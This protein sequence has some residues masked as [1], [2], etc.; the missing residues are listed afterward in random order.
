MAGPRQRPGPDGAPGVPTSPRCRLPARSWRLEPF[1]PPRGLPVLRGHGRPCGRVHEALT[2]SCWRPGSCLPCPSLHLGVP[3]VSTPLSRCCCS[4]GSEEDTAEATHGLRCVGHC[5]RALS[6]IVLVQ[7]SAQ[8]RT[9]CSEAHFTD[10][11]AEGRTGAEGRPPTPPPPRRTP[12]NV[13]AGTTGPRAG[14]GTESLVSDQE[15]CPSR[16]LTQSRGDP[17]VAGQGPPRPSVSTCFGVSI[18]TSSCTD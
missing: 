17:K 8:P 1:F 15:P 11:D 14:C 5:T 16:V 10:G 12:H 18:S 9:E 6:D 13:C 7:G 3:T 4:P 2:L